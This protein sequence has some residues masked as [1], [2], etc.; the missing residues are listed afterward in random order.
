MQKFISEEEMEQ[1]EFLEDSIRQ[2]DSTE[3]VEMFTDLIATIIENVI[4]RY[5]EEYESR[6]LSE[7]DKKVE[8]QLMP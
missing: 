7:K 2:S 5:I 8:A 1:I 3:E 6:N 4:E